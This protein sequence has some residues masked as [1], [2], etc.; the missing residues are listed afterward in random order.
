ML[1]ISENEFLA[2]LE[3]DRVRAHWEE[4]GYTTERV[5]TEDPQAV[6][7]A[8]DTA[9]LFG[10]GRFVVVGGPAAPL[11]AA[12]G[13]LAE[14]ADSPPPGL[15]AAIVA[16]RASKLEKAL[17]GHAEIFKPEAPKPWEVPDWVV[18]F[19]KGRGRVITKEAAAALVEAVGTNLRD[20]ATAA[21]QVATA[22][23]GTINP[24]AVAKLFRGLESQLFTF[25]E[26][27]LRRDRPAAL[28]H[29]GAL[30]R[31]G[32]HPLVILA[33]LAKQF[34]AL[35]AVRDAGATPPAALAKELDVSPGYVN[36]AKK[37]ARAFDPASVRRAFRLLADA[38]LAL[39][40]GEQSEERPA[41]L[42]ME[43]LIAEIT[44]DRVSSGAQR[45]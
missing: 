45:R 39:K 21:E 44:A 6:F 41:E 14:W 10:D 30:M 34:R 25:L 18:R 4:K 31:S 38:D 22:T 27:T 12:A 15:A 24:P 36:R 23:T 29:L 7:Y 40:G 20:A 17:T 33:A 42:L 9:S 32:E 5:S 26:A 43:L 35:A 16:T 13:R 2:S 19:L 3:L 1:I 11:E 28:R 8:L 37:H